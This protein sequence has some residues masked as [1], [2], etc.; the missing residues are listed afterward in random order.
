MSKHHK[1][2]QKPISEVAK[3]MKNLIPANIPEV[4]ALNSVFD[5]IASEESI[6]TGVIAFRDFLY[7]FFDRL[8]LEGHLYATP[9]NKPSSMTDYPFLDGI[10]NLLA[11]I[12][13]HG[14]LAESGDSLLVTQISSQTAAKI[15]NSNMIKCL[16]FLTICGFVFS[17]I[18]LDS[19]NIKILEAL[20]LEA[21]YPNN[22]IMLTGLKALSVAN[23]EL[24]T[25]RRFWNDHNLLLCDY[26]P[27][28]AEPT[29]TG[30]IVK[31]YLHPLPDKVRE[32]A[33]KL[34]QRYTNRGMTCSVRILG[35]INFAYADISK[36]KKILS[37]TDIYALSVWQISI[38]MKNGYC[39]FVRPKKVNKYTQ[40]IEKFPLALQEKIT[41]GYGC[42]RK[43]GKS[44][45]GG[46]QGIS[47]PLDN[48]IFD[49]A[50][51]IEIWIDN[52]APSLHKQ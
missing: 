47:I 35:D 6:R 23:M 49:I 15:T 20:P 25:T 10:S 7:L 38:S 45:Q 37:P 17:T 44:C 51:D 29:E 34:H 3:F 18:D 42:D 19:K 24:R 46:C 26:R 16:R 9:P 32:F 27:I 48:S 31:D 50:E 11:E 52:E 28:K 1:V 21:S 41:A 40:I 33:L 36:S 8:I 13:Y 43:R 5:N 39:I 2:T 30:E 14:V 22:P 12:G 4:Y